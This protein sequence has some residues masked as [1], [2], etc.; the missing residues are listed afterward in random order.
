MEDKQL[1][2]KAKAGDSA[3][4]EQLVLLHQKVVYNYCLRMCGNREDALD[5]SQD[6]FLKAYKSLAFFKGE[7]SFS[8]W[9]YRLTVN[10]CI[11]FLRSRK[12]H[13]SVSLTVENDDGEKEVL[14]IPDERESIEKH[15]ERKELRAAIERGIN[16]LSEAHRQV[17][18][19]REINGCSYAEISEILDINEGT[20]KSRISRARI[21][22]AKYLKEYRNFSAAD[23]SEKTKGGEPYGM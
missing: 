14:P 6:A 9:M 20:V 19:L 7:S 5:L 12:R 13:K 22:L 3:A 17:L 15:V 11:D 1:V 18:V 2:D 21:E 16:M 10:V 4:F 23:T 8:T